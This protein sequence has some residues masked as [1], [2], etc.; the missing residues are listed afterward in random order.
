MGLQLL[1]VFMDGT[2]G[3]QRGIAVSI[4]ICEWDTRLST[5]DC[6]LYQ[7][8]WMGNTALSV[9]LQFVSVLVCGTHGLLN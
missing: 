5:W 3:S 4:G 1:L 6:K 7:Y 2:H 8:L 9:G